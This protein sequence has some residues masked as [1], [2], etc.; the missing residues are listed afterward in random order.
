MALSP[1]PPLAC[2]QAFEASARLLSFTRAGQELHLS[3]SAVSRQIAQLETFLGRR[4]F[5]REHNALRLTPAGE[6][7][8]VDVR[9]M[10]ELCTSATSSLMARV[11][12]SRLTV[13]CT[14]GISALWLTP[15]IGSFI[16]ANP[17]VDL[18]IIVRDH[19]GVVSPAEYDIGIFLLR[20][21]DMPGTRTIKLFD[22]QVFPVCSPDYL[23]GR[24]VTPTELLS[25]TLLVLEDAERSW[26]SWHSWFERAGLE[27]PT[28]NQTIIVNSYPVI[29]Q[30]AAYGKGIALGWNGVIDLLL[31]QGVLVRASDHDATLGSAYFLTWPSERAESS[32]VRRF[33]DWV[34]AQTN[35]A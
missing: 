15:R 7:Y 22:E 29:V 12:K 13:S 20:K 32:A 8:T 4:L 23:Q 17:D 3:T 24:K 31:A 1:L 2:L 26:M 16:D 19:F 10:L 34:L 5:V 27:R 35:I 14:E 9:R 28:L 21:P 33:R 25:C 6:T 11:V 30:L 18:R